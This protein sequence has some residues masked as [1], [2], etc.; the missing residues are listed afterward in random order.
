M[1]RNEM[2]WNEM[3]WRNWNKGI[4]MEDGNE[5]IDMKNLKWMNNMNEG[6]RM[7]G[8]ERFDMHELDMNE[9]NHWLGRKNWNE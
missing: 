9:W 1:K 4:D 3:K 5:R 6:K 2:K 7:N 8:H